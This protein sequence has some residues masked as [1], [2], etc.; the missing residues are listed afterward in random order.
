MGV[1]MGSA[2]KLKCGGCQV[3]CSYIVNLYQLSFFVH[4]NYIGLV[5]LVI[6]Q[7]S[8]TQNLFFLQ[9]NWLIMYKSI[10]NSFAVTDRD[11]L[12]EYTYIKYHLATC[13]L[14]HPGYQVVAMWMKIYLEDDSRYFGNDWGPAWTENVKLCSDPE[15]GVELCR[16]HC[17]CV[18]LCWIHCC[19][20]HM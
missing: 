20:L 7:I 2:T 9:K 16:I 6:C 10:K 13:L 11:L 3:Q 12:H 19:S 17:V 4:F 5:K 18:E 8:Y 1:G 14:I 15:E